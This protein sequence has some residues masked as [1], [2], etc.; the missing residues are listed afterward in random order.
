VGLFARRTA[1]RAEW[2]GIFSFLASLASILGLFFSIAAWRRA[3]GAEK[4]AGEAREAVRR[5]NASEDFRELSD[6]AR[7]LLA[8]TQ[9]GQFEA[10]LLRSRDLL[11]GIAQ[12]R[13]R[14]QAFLTDDKEQ[15]DEITREISRISRALSL[16][17]AAITPAVRE[18]LLMA[19][20][21][22]SLKGG[23]END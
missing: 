8:S 7:E 3:A 12:A 13:H 22:A 14:W 19:R 9:G 17:Q 15:I 11:T 20:C 10:A 4:A 18:K 23:F 5:S 6:K 16:G 1:L 2:L 21:C